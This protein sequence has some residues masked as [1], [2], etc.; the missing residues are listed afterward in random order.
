[1]YIHLACQL[2]VTLF[3]PRILV[4]GTNN[5]MMILFSATCYPKKNRPSAILHVTSSSL[6][7]CHFPYR[8]VSNCKSM[9]ANSQIVDLIRS[10]TVT[11][12]I[13]KRNMMMWS[14]APLYLFFLRFNN[15]D[16]VCLLA[17]WDF[18]NFDFVMF[19]FYLIPSFFQGITQNMC[20]V[21]I[22]H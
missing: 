11:L 19:F 8:Q 1:M 17:G 2:G 10:F 18:C 3:E 13:Y 6:S 22:H 14:R 5:K 21:V 7:L 12:N 20:V 9:S 16:Q 15:C 4:Q